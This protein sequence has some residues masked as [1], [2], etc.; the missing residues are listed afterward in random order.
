MAASTTTTTTTAERTDHHARRSASASALALVFTPLPPSSIPF[1]ASSPDSSDDSD[2]P[3]IHGY[4]RSRSITPPTPPRQRP[5]AQSGP[6]TPRPAH[7]VTRRHSHSRQHGRS[8]SAGYLTSP[9]MIYNN[10]S[11]AALPRAQFTIA[12]SYEPSGSTSGQATPRSRSPGP[13][14]SPPPYSL[15]PPE[16]DPNSP[17]LFKRAASSPHL[18]SP[19]QSPAPLHQYPHSSSS[20]RI[21]SSSTLHP[22][23]RAARHTY[24]HHAD[25]SDDPDTDADASMSE[26]TVIYTSS[27]PTLA[28][29]LRARLLGKGKGRADEGRM[30]PISTALGVIGAGETETEGEESPRHLPTARINPSA[31]SLPFLSSLSSSAQAPVPS[32]LKPYLPLLWELSRLLSIVPAVFGTMYNLYHVF[33][34]PG[35]SFWWRVEYFVSALWV[36]V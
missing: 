30:R 6:N 15:T 3:P 11:G 1:V 23:Q 8:N 2:R 7:F 24:S 31:S 27:Q 25:T 20:S 12:A 29:T 26:D 22:P 14:G 33:F 35:D 16:T 21:P 5:R 10:G 13:P 19:P 17:F 34:P 9:F 18:H 28:G 4:S 36:S 32:P